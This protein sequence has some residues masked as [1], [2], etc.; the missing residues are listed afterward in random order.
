MPPHSLEVSSCGRDESYH[1]VDDFSLSPSR[2]SEHSEQGLRGSGWAPQPASLRKQ[3]STPG[4]RTP[5]A[6]LGKQHVGLHFL[7]WCDAPLTATWRWDLHSPRLWDWALCRRR[8]PDF[9]LT[10]GVLP[11][12]EERWLVAGW[13]HPKVTELW[14]AGGEVWIQTPH[15]SKDTCHF[16]PAGNSSF[17]AYHLAIVPDYF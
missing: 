8:A 2:T 7:F 10:S 3:S 15:L 11:S 4:V 9:T 12:Q 1:L 14:G 5:W 6:K 17:A 16:S 13:E